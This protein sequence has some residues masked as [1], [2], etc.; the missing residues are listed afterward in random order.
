MH[1]LDEHNI[2]D[3]VTATFAAAPNPRLKAVMT[4]LVRHLHDFARDVALTPDEWIETV[5]FLTAV[6]QTCSPTRQEF[7]LLS[8]TLG[9]SALVNAPN[10]RAAQDATPSSLLGPF[11]RENAPDLPLRGHTAVDVPRP[12]V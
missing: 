3:A 1:D 6:G 7:I 5:Q 2:T 10:N 12:L 8:D 9:L 4:S 11:Y